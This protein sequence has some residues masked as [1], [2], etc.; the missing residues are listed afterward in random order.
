MSEPMYT[1]GYQPGQSNPIA[2]PDQLALEQL[3]VK[4]ARRP[5]VRR[6]REN[7]RA[8]L[9]ADVEA[10]TPDGAAG[11]DR[12]LDQWV[13]GQIAATINA[14]PSR[15]RLFWSVDN[16][17]RSWFGQVF[18]GAAVAIDNPDNVNRVA[19]LDGAWSYRLEGRFG[20]PPTAQ[21]SIQITLA[22]SGQLRWG[23]AIGTLVNRDIVTDEQGRFTVTLDTSPANGR[24]N[25]IQLRKGPLQMAIRDSHG[26]WGQQATAYTLHVVG[27]PELLPPPS[28]DALVDEVASGMEDFVKFWLG[29]KNN[30]WDYPDPNQ[31]IGPFKRVREGGWGT[32]AGGRFAIADDQALVITTES[33]GS[34]YTGF[35]VSDPWTI[36]PTPIHRTTSRNINQAKANPDGSYTYV[37]SHVDPGVA[38]WIDTDGLREG[39][40]MLR[41]QN[42]GQNAEVETL[43][44]DTRL[45]TLDTLPSVLPDGC[46]KVTLDE[47]RE[48]IQ[49]RMAL[50]RR[51]TAG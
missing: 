27:G 47:R 33:G 49:R 28:E 8:M 2:T 24:A 5:E 50:H 42:L 17:P 35:Q 12:A 26:D 25:H 38:N 9:L 16:T 11:L 7:A 34:E 37:V 41:W 10:N 48:E 31:T 20:H 46:P 22:D 18:P 39:W 40:F 44:R 51:R 14:D 32:Q 29:F 43:V 6:A 23:D 21:M 45:V 4:L 13:M 36:S 19:P 1:S 30:F 3:A 15:P